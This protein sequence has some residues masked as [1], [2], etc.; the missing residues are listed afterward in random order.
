MKCKNCGH[1]MYKNN[2]EWV[3]SQNIIYTTKCNCGCINP[4]PEKEC[5]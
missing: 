1:K 4:E 2:K 5:E 3:H